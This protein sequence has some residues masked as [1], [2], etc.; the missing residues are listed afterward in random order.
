[1]QGYKTVAEAALPQAQHLYGKNT[2][3]RL[4]QYFDEIQD[5]NTGCTVTQYQILKGITL[6]FQ[7]IHEEHLDYGDELPQLSSD[8]IAIQHCR[9]GRFEGEYPDGECIYMGPGSLSINLP[10]WAPVRNS[11]PLHHYHGFYLA[12][13]PYQAQACIEDLE[14]L[15]GPLGIDL[16]GL[17]EHLSSKNRL[18]LY[19]KDEKLERVIAAIY[20]AYRT[21]HIE[22]LKPQVLELLQLLS[23]QG[24][25]AAG[26]VNTS[27]ATK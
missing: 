21:H 3:V 20:E 25:K 2:S 8:L 11:F 23:T 5:E 15:L 6:V 26:R 17:H 12:I 19:D 13:M 10:A 27:L 1:M 9:E 24:M 14:E 16:A 7:D 18:A 22:R 4:I